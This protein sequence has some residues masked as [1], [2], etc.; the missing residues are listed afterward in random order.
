[1]GEETPERERIASKRTMTYRSD[2]TD[3]MKVKISNHFR[4]V[5]LVNQNEN[6]LL[7]QDESKEMIDHMNDLHLADKQKSLTK[8]NTIDEDKP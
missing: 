6:Y 4:K 8:Q 7:E 2:N 3:N 1:M 5:L